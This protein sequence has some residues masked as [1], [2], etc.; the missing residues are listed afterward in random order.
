MRSVVVCVRCCLFRSSVTSQRVNVNAPL[1]RRF[2]Q[3]VAVGADGYQV[4][5]SQCQ[6][7]SFGNGFDVV[8]FLGWSITAPLA[9]RSTLKRG[10]S[11]TLP[12][13]G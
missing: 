8:D 5:L 4:G 11:D 2:N 10:G 9:N 3:S 1:D 6:V 13:V 12:C 7:G